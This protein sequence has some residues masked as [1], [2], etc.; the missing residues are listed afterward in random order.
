[1][2]CALRITGL[3]QLFTLEPTAEAVVADVRA[4]PHSH[5]GPHGSGL[6]QGGPD[7]GI[8]Q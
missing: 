4:Q 1:M 8:Q 3:D 5:S 2:R 7:G 6:N